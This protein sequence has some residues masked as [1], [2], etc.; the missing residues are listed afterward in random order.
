MMCSGWGNASMA[1]AAN[2]GSFTTNSFRIQINVNKDNSAYVNEKITIDAGK[3]GINTIERTLPAFSVIEYTDA[4]GK[5]LKKVR[6][7]IKIADVAVEND[8]FEIKRTPGKYK[9]T[10][11]R[12]NKK[13]TGKKT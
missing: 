12:D 6:N 9:I 1:K 5:L 11:G 13:I 3:K 2:K 4:T 10:I 7:P 8:V